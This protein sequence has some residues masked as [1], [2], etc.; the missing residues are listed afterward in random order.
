[1]L[2]LNALP[3]GPTRLSAYNEEF[4]YFADAA[5]TPPLIH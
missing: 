3:H 4:K 2:P 1:M 5:Q